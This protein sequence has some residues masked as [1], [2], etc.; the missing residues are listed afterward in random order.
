[1]RNQLATIIRDHIARCPALPV[2][3]DDLSVDKTTGALSSI[4][5]QLQA[6]TVLQE[7]ID[8]SKELSCPFSLILQTRA[9]RSS[10]DLSRWRE[11]LD[12]VAR[13]VEANKIAEVAPYNFPDNPEITDY[14]SIVQGDDMSTVYILQMRVTVNYTRIG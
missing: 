12:D 7:Y 13:W 8:G 9:V 4:A 14:A 5:V 2:S 11:R 3:A 10:I 6:P 1:M